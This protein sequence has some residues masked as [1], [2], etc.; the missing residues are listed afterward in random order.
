MRSIRSFNR[1]RTSDR[2]P[3]RGFVLIAALVLAV[4]YFGLMELMLVDS[5]RELAEA[6]RFRA[7]VVAGIVAE[8][9]VELAAHEMTSSGGLKVTEDDEQGSM[10]GELRRTGGDGFEITGKGKTGGATAQ[11][12]TVYVQGRVDA[13]GKVMIDYTMHGQ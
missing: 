8:N 10:E 9:A 7:R 11:E 6:R 1:A 3:E 12:A 4:L 5:G 2:R 13:N